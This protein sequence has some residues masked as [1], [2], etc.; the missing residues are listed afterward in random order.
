MGRA[1]TGPPKRLEP[2]PPT[3]GL[4]E[5]SAQARTSRTVPRVVAVLGIATAV[6][7]ASTMPTAASAAATGTT[8]SP[9]AAAAGWLVQQFSNAQN[10]RVPAGDHIELSY[11]DGTKDVYFYDGG[12]TADATFALAAAKAGNDKIQKAMGYLAAHLDEY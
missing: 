3:E 6:A 12:G 10:K 1:G 8:T 7:L 9:A 11:N 4:L 5:M 2:R